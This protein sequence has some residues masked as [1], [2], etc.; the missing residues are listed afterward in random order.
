MVC[1]PVEQEPDSWFLLSNLLPDPGRVVAGASLDGEVD[2]HVRLQRPDVLQVFQEEVEGPESGRDVCPRTLDHR[3]IAVLLDLVDEVSGQAMALV[4][5]R[6]GHLALR[7]DPRR[8]ERMIP[9][10][11]VRL[12]VA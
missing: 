5:L 10:R 6:P 11:G 4:H 1:V 9:H 3:C 7:V 8:P 2:S 12:S